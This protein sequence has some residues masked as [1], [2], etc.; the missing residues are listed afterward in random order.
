MTAEKHGL[1]TIEDRIVNWAGWINKLE[2]VDKED[3]K[4]IDKIIRAQD[5]ETRSVVKAMFVQ[6]PKQS[7]YFIA[8][9]LAIPP[10]FI[11]RSL[12]RVKDAIRVA[13]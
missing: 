1:G 6:W 11:N 3:A 10:S 9:E 8:A 13:A 2:P 4:K 7:I 12:M 5:E